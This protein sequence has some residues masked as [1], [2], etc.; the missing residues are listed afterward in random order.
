M[1]AGTVKRVLFQIGSR[2]PVMMRE[3][4]ADFLAKRGRGSYVT[5]HISAAEVVTTAITPEPAPVVE[6]V[7]EVVA[8]APKRRGR[9]P[10][11]A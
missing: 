1:G 7:A 11:S 8:E 3:D 2:R 6:D 10:K 4:I 5:A 9:K